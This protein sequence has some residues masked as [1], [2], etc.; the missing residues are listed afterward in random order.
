[1]KEAKWLA[2]FF[3]EDFFLTCGL[4]FVWG[5]NLE[6]PD[7]IL[8]ALF[9]WITC[10][11]AALSTKDIAFCIFSCDFPF[12]ASLRATSRFFLTAELTDS[13][14]FDD[15]RALLAVFVTGMLLV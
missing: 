1:M 2:Y 10:F 9:L 7:L 3:L 8:A 13:F 15:L 11:F 4:D 12:L 14:F 5:S 6:R